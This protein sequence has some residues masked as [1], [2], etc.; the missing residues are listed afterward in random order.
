ML[1]DTLP[2]RLYGSIPR[3]ESAPAG[4]QTKKG[5]IAPA[6]FPSFPPGRNG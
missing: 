1:A 5:Q 4:A 6:L 3:L 2:G